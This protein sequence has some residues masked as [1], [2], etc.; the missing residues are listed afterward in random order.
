MAWNYLDMGKRNGQEIQLL[1]STL[2]KH[3]QCKRQVEITLPLYQKVDIIT[4]FHNLQKSFIS[5]VSHET[6]E[7]DVYQVAIVL[8]V[9]IKQHL[10]ISL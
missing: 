9:L 8:L 2:T 7:L 10:N 5:L 1:A 3:S 4:S 6:L